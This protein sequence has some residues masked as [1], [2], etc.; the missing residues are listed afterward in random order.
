MENLRSTRSI[1]RDDVW[2]A[3][4]ALLLEGKRPTI[5][6]VRQKIGRGSPNTVSPM[7]EE[8]FATLGPRMAQLKG[9]SAS[10]GAGDM[11][12]GE[13]NAPG[14]PAALAQAMQTVWEGALQQSQA[15]A[16]ARLDAERGVLAQ[17]AQALQTDRETLAQ[18]QVVLDQQRVAMEQ[19]LAVAHAQIKMQSTRLTE[20]EAA[21]RQKDQLAQQ[22]QQRLQLLD[23]EL[24]A[25]RKARDEAD[26]S[27][28]EQ[29]KALQEAAQVQQHRALQEVDRARQ[30]AK[31]WM[32]QCRTDQDKFSRQE[33][34]WQQE[35]KAMQ[36]QQE[37]KEQQ[38]QIAKHAIDAQRLA[39]EQHE[40]QCALLEQRRAADAAQLAS[41][42]AQLKKAEQV[43]ANL[44]LPG[45]GAPISKKLARPNAGVGVGRPA[46]LTGRL[47]RRSR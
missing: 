17:Q 16:E 45:M 13:G 25:T 11:V 47:G 39:T 38:L 33:Q 3:A 19:A 27:H 15:V 8:W 31:Q 30:D 37:E 40:K 12:V 35:R 2:M 24:F 7:L 6:R 21:A 18:A 46:G 23:Q 41:L 43:P 28:A 26:K 42:Q 44:P 34:D 5:E 32:A 36:L 10:A 4:D 14:V 20:L 9:G 29:V 1:Q 22:Q